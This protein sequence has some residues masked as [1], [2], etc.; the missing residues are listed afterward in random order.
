MAVEKKR[1]LTG[2]G[3]ILLSAVLL[4][5]LAPCAAEDGDG[6]WVPGEVLVVYRGDDGGEALRASTTSYKEGGVRLYSALSSAGGRSVALVRAPGRSTD[7]LLEEY[8]ADPDVVSVSPNYI[9]RLLDRTPNDPRFNEQWGLY[10]TGQTG[11]TSGADISAPRAWSFAPT[12]RR[13]G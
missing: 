3:I 1:C 11:G 2:I 7:E 10:N 4:L 13:T 5:P 6:R 9:I 12:Q 8:G